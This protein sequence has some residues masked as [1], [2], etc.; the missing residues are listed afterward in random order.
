MHLVQDLSE[1]HHLV[2]RV[3]PASVTVDDRELTRSF[4]LTPSQCH[5]DFPV[6]DI[7]GFDA[8][9]IQQ[10]LD[11]QPALVLIGTGARQHLAP[12]ALMGGFLTRGVGVEAMDSAACARTFN[13]LASEGRQVVAVFLIG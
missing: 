7:A 6:R 1:G 10:V 13:L 8:A 3:G 11:L 4:L 12:P 5:E 2:R 9:A